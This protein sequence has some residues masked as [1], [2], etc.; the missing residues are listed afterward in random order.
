MEINRIRILKKS[1]TGVL[2]KVGRD[3]IPASWE[4]FNE[5]FDIVDNVWAVMKES[6]KQKF[7]EIEDHINDAV[8]S[9]MFQRG[10]GDPGQKLAHLALL[11]DSI[12]KIQEKLGCSMADA[13]QLV[14]ERI[15]LMNPFMSK[16]LINENKH[17]NFNKHREERKK[18]VSNEPEKQTTAIGDLCPALAKL[19][20]QMEKK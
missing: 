13:M 5:K 2:L 7:E 15:A 14:R 12:S 17:R 19:K 4:E 9:F 3:A 16:P 6:E 8:V 11:G 1:S 18:P 20:E 10:N